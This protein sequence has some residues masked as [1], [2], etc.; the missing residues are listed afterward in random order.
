MFSTSFTIRYNGA[1]LF[2]PIKPINESYYLCDKRFY[3]DPILEMYKT[4]LEQSI[5]IFLI[6][7]NRSIFYQLIKTGSHIETKILADTKVKLQKR[8]KKGGQSAQRIG[9]I[10][11]QKESRYI[12]KIIEMAINVYLK[13]N[14]TKYLI[15]SIVL[16]GPAELKYSVRKH[17]EY[18]KYFDNMTVNIVDTPELNETTIHNVYEKSSTELCTEGNKETSMVIEK[19]KD[20][21]T[22]AN[23]KLVFGQN[24]VLENLKNCMLETILIN[25]KQYV[26]MVNHLNTYGC[27]VLVN[28]KSIG[29]DDIDIIGIR[30]Y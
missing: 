4:D 27:K 11:Q 28:T 10:R 8:Q 1:I 30:Y 9:R 17:A 12:D 16:G 23:E 21:M 5:G 26:D 2:E 7:G 22:D 14:C 13:E 6:S 20:M 15:S 18:K 25:D 24:E 3:L 29:V 19:I